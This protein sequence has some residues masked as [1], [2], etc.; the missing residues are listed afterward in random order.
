M[1]TKEQMKQIF[2][3]I[4]TASQAR[5]NSQSTVPEHTIVSS[6]LI[7][8][9]FRRNQYDITNMIQISLHRYVYRVRQVNDD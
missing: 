3:L 1:N 8:L 9:I 2:S 4:L 5:E 6:I 7:D